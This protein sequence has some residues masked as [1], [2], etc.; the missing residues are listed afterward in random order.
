MVTARETL[1]SGVALPAA[2]TFDLPAETAARERLE[3][4]R[5]V[6]PEALSVTESRNADSFGELRLSSDGVLSTPTEVAE[7]GPAA[8][9]VAAANARRNVILDDAKSPSNPRP[10]PYLTPADSLRR[11][12][13]T[14][15]LTGILSFGF[16]QY[17]IQPTAA[18]AFTQSNP[19]PKAP[20][21]VGGDVR[22]GSFNVLNYFVTFGRSEDRGARTEAELDQQ[23]AKIVDAINGLGAEVVALQEIQDTSDEASLANDPDAALD[24]LVAALNADPGSELTWA[25]VPAPSP[26][27]NTDEIRNALIYQPAKVERVGAPGALDDPA[28]ANARTPLA[29]TFEAGG[30]TFTV[31]ANH[32][33]SKG[34]TGT[35]DNANTGQ[36]SFNG[37]RVR[38]A[39]AL[40]GFIEELQLS[41]GD[42]D[43]LALGDLNSYTREDPIDALVE[44]GGLR[45]VAT[46]RIPEADRYSFVFDGAQGNLDDEIATPALDAKITGA[47]IWHI[48]A[49]EPDA[50]QY[51][52]P[53]ELF[54]PDR[55]AASDHDPSVVGLKTGE[56]VAR[57]V[58]V[59]GTGV[60]ERGSTFDFSI[61]GTRGAPA[62][63]ATFTVGS[64]TR[65]GDVTC[66]RIAGDRALFGV[67]DTTS[68]EG[69]V[70][71]EYYVEDKPHKPEGLI[72]LGDGRSTAP[73]AGC[74][75]K[76]PRPGSGSPIAGGSIA[77]SP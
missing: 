2:S 71:R 24:A 23:E 67:A 18:P 76:L 64:S 10:V 51:T 7:P 49:D 34:G 16:G 40:R 9:A 30:Q 37:D 39:R 28:F 68:G 75:S 20:E 11:G 35:G 65:S 62:G 25:K 48:N 56:D 55:F 50:F 12:D 58:V 60:S 13:T 4:M 52:G 8:A 45:D 27:T 72:E 36:G 54:A 73:S 6:A 26:Y 19:R 21:P 70:F 32:F 3:G 22:I 42:A 14:T 57:D 29:S 5:I 31:I 43:V 46:A 53:E 41:S 69:T 47:D 63:R 74:S 38:Q 61:T 1:E 59:S 77:V 44:E 15:G 66:L 17:R 33:K